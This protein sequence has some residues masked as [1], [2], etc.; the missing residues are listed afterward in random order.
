M[1]VNTWLAAKMLRPPAQS[2]PETSQTLPC[3]TALSVDH[4]G[5]L[6]KSSLVI[7]VFHKEQ[8]WGLLVAH[9]SRS[10]SISQQQLKVVQMVV[11]QFSIAIAQNILLTQARKQAKREAIISSI[12]TLLHSLKDIPLQG[13]LEK[14][15]AAFGGCG[16]R[17]CIHNQNS[18]RG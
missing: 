14:A 10:Y 12:G 17:L 16:G 5:S 18:D 13:A 15:V 9:H 3:L 1:S 6:I 7:P 11:D 2:A 4:R 8:L